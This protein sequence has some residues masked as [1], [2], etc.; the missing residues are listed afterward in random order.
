MRHVYRALLSIQAFF[1]I[2]ISTMT[3]SYGDAAMSL[4]EFQKRPKLLLMIVID[5]F[6]ADYLTRFESKFLPSQNKNGEV[7]G[8]QY[9]MSQGAYFPFGQ[10]DIMQSITAPGHATVLTGAYPYQAG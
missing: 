8:F 1:F 5:Q 3:P 7:G 2:C 4:Q 10:Y 6:R 9:L